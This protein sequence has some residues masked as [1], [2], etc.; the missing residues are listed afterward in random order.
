MRPWSHI[1]SALVFLAN[2]AFHG[3][4][5]IINVFMMAIKAVCVL[6]LLLVASF[7]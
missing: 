3:A 1:R 6:V 2:L 5:C 4:K 7:L